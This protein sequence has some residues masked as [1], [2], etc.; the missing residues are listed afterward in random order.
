[1]DVLVG[2]ATSAAAA[3]ADWAQ[4]QAQAQTLIETNLPAGSHINLD[5]S[6]T[7]GIGDKA[8]TATGTTSIE[9]TSVSFTG[10]YVLSD[11]TF[12]TIGDLV[13]GTHPPTVADMQ[14]QAQTVLGRI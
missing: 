5:T 4:E 10:I 6:N 9:G 8:A 13:L 2:V 7:A 1:M 12:F 14:A 11:A 3:Q